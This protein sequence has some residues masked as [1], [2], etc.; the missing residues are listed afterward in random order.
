MQTLTSKCSRQ[1]GLLLTY[2]IGC[3]MLVA[4]PVHANNDSGMQGNPV[5]FLPK[6]VVPAAPTVTI[7]VEKPQVDP[8]LQALLASYLV[9]SNFQISGVKALPFEDVAAVFTPMINRV[10]TVAQLLEAA[11]A[12]TKMYQDRGYPLSAAFLP[13]QTFDKNNVVITVVE[14]YVSRVKVEGNPGGSEARL[15]RI[16]EQLL[17]DKPLHR[18]TF[19]RVAG[20]LS[21]QPGVKIAANIAPPTTTDGAAE[22]TL[23]VKRKPITAGVGLNYLQPGVRGLLSVSTNGL[24]PFGEQIT[25][26]TL[27]PGGKQKEKYYGINYVQPIGRNGLLGKLNWSDYRAQPENT[28]LES[29]FIQARY[30]TTTS[31][32]GGTLSYPF[33]LDNMHN[34]TVSGGAYEASTSQ[35]YTFMP[36]YGGSSAEIHSTVRVLQADAAW[37]DV[38]V[39]PAGLVRTRSLNVVLSQGLKGLGKKNNGSDIDLGFTKATLHAVQSNQLPKGLGLVVSTHM[40]YSNHRLPSSEQIGFGGRLFGLGYPAGEMAGDKGWG[41]SAEINRLFNT[42]GTMIK[43]IQPYFLVDH[44]RVYSNAAALTRNTLGS[45]GFGVRLSGG[46]VYAID[47]AV[48]KPTADIPLNSNSRSPR[49][50]LSY[51]YQMD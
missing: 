35:T 30:K 46:S 27:Q 32:F 17:E 3:L 20:I 16:A 14:G 26:S 48:A 4:I 23:V 24:T 40:Q 7:N 33:I 49:V 44:S 45:V 50:N 25:L 13:A 39:S 21:L 5:D 1:A 29:Q 2:C 37:M 15:Q 18:A 43:T 8:A 6:V 22:L 36:Q 42:S 9:P 47:L 41:V 11:N 10:T 19:E 38:K 51:S 28:G 31:R 12:V 34:L